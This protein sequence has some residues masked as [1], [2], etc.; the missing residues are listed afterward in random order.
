MSSLT[1]PHLAEPGRWSESLPVWVL[2]VVGMLAALFPAFLRIAPNRLLT[3][4]AIRPQAWPLALA[5]LA[6]AV[7]TA[8]PARIARPVVTTLAWLVVCSLPLLAGV[9][10]GIALSEASAFSVRA[11]LGAGF[12][13]MWLAA[14]LLLLDR[15]RGMRVPTR[16]ALWVAVLAV[17]GGCAWV[18]V[19]D[20][21]G[22]VR[23]WRAQRVPFALATVEHLRLAAVTLVL[24]LLVGAPLG[25]WVWRRRRSD[26]LLVGVLAFLQTV[27]SLALFALLIG[28]FAWL[29]HQWPALGSLGFG[30]TGA[31]PAVFALVLYALLPVVRYT[32]AGLDAVPSDAREAAR[33]LGMSRAQLLWRVQLP[34]GWPVLLAG[35][36]IV[37]VQT[38]GLAAVAALIGAGGLG[39]FVFL[40]IGQGAIDMVLLGTLAI[41]ALALAIDFLFQGALALT[42][43]AP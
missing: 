37:A 11:Q 7:C 2:S 25:W 39:R 21:L 43:R 31:A 19:F 22:L 10:A 27:P 29:A 34:L 6:I 28:P 32:V 33:G 17:L 16:T 36:R 42:E 24:A 38:V 23:E 13:L 8:L 1:R 18:G 40:G 15:L 35:L 14:A 20:A 9:D 12:W 4:E 3:G 26:G 5:W 30:G 41:I